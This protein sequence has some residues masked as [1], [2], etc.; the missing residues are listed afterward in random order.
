MHLV[1][2]FNSIK[3]K[4]M[5][6]NKNRNSLSKMKWQRQKALNGGNTVCMFQFVV[7]INLFA[8]CYCFFF[9]FFVCH[10][11][12][13]V[14]YTTYARAIEK[15]GKKQNGRMFQERPFVFSQ[16]NSA[17]PW[18]SEE[19]INLAN[20]LS[21]LFNSPSTFQMIFFAVFEHILLT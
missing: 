16:S 9:S 21:F 18:D 8:C 12:H 20:F 19:E 7:Q 17:K 14:I 6:V 13:F 5:I 10:F 3:E 11:L 15:K 1:R 2:K 4:K